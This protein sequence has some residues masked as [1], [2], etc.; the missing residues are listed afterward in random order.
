MIHMKFKFLEIKHITITKIMDIVAKYY[1]LDIATIKGKMR[2]KKII[3]E[4]FFN[5][6]NRTCKEYLS[7][8][9]DYRC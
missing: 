4:R 8:V 3:R 6:I 5:R 7:C 9:G 2:K 1:G